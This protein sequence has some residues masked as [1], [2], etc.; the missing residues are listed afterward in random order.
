MH[1]L[2]LDAVAEVSKLIITMTRTDA[3]K[4][5]PMHEPTGE[6]SAT[7]DDAVATSGMPEAVP[8]AA[9]PH[10]Q[11]GRRPDAAEGSSADE[12]RAAEAE[13]TQG[14]EFQLLLE[15]LQD[16]L[17]RQGWQPSLPILK[18]STRSLGLLIAV[19]VLLRLE[20]GLV[21]TLNSIPLL[22]RVLLLVG[23]LR[24]ALFARENL[25]RQDD[26]K[27]LNERLQQLIRETIG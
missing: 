27:R 3:L 11:E 7:G 5:H 8:G 16:W 14:G 10:E 1:A 4:P 6:R 2:A 15:K 22:G 26:R 17:A 25:L 19:C 9:G 18:R 20:G 12:S 13:Q 21:S 24:V 23:L